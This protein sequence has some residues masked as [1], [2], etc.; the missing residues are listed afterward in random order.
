MAQKDPGP[1]QAGANLRPTFG[2]HEA[3][4]APRYDTSRIQLLEPGAG[5]CPHMHPLGLRL[6]SHLPALKT[7]P[8]I[9]ASTSATDTPAVDG[10]PEEVY[11]SLSP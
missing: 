7:T 5:A 2:R 9:G 11:V 10:A 4:G 1:S 8:A 3:G 6:S